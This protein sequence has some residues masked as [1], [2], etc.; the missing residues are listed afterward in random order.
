MLTTVSAHRRC[1]SSRASTSQTHR[2]RPLWRGTAVACTW[3]SSSGRMKF[4]SFDMPITTLPSL[5]RREPRAA[6]GERLGQ[7]R[8]DTAVQEAELLAQLVADRHP[9]AH[10]AVARVD[11][12]HLE[13]IDGVE[14]AIERDRRFKAIRDR[15]QGSGLH[16][17]YNVLDANSASALRTG[18]DASRCGL[19]PP[20]TTTRVTGPRR[21]AWIRSSCS[22]VPYGS[23]R[24]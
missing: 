3:P 2:V 11:V 16:R 24:P 1:S 19:W 20:P 6:R 13:A 21:R 8:D 22:S 18:S 7:R 9:A 5:Y 4:V 17:F 15:G 12:D 10:R 23:S 14:A